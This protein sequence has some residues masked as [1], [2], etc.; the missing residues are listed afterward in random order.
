MKMRALFFATVACLGISLTAHA[1]DISDNITGSLSPS[2][3]F[4]GSFL[5]NSTSEII[6]GATI[7]VTAPSGGTTYNFFLAAADSA[8][9]GLATMTDGLGDSFVLAVQWHPEE[10]LHDLRLFAAV[11]EA[12]R[13]YATQRTIP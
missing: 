2:G 6:D 10:R 11:V 3:S 13:A 4:T 8:I 9:G 12:A 7:H 1:A 5:I